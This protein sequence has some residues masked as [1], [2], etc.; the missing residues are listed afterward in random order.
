MSKPHYPTRDV[1][2]TL[3]DKAVRKRFGDRLERGGV[4]LPFTVRRPAGWSYKMKGK[5]PVLQPHMVN[6][7]FMISGRRLRQ[8]VWMITLPVALQSQV[9]TWLLIQCG[10]MNENHGDVALPKMRSV[11][12]DNLQE[13][14]T[15]KKPKAKKAKRHGPLRQKEVARW[16][17][18]PAKGR[19]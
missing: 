5:Q 16:G 3:N 8:G 11:G 1:P 6:S 9:I 19:G 14:L 7:L 2:V 15:Q 4:K 18:S 10:P 12:T 17:S 13:Q